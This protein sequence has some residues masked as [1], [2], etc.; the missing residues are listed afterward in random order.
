MIVR[1]EAGDLVGHGAILRRGSAGSCSRVR[2]KGTIAPALG[3]ETPPAGSSRWKLPR[4]G[5]APSWDS[6][7]LLAGTRGIRI[8]PRSDRPPRASRGRV[9]RG[10][11]LARPVV[12]GRRLPRCSRRRRRG[13]HG[14]P[15]R[16]ARANPRAREGSARCPHRRGFRLR[17]GA[18]TRE[19][20]FAVARFR[21]LSSARRDRRGSG[22]R[23]RRALRPATKPPEGR[24]CRGRPAGRA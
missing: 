23:R 21:A 7:S 4:A 14:L 11:V 12:D 15:L 10:S 6:S 17:R 13:L 18:G 1:D 3:S 2:L 24:R 20:G 16:A 5:R 22:S 19:A 9:L 8:A